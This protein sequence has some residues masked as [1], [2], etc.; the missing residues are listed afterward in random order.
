MADLSRHPDPA[1]RIGPLA[2][3]VRVAQE[4]L[5]A[6]T[7]AAEAARREQI[8]AINRLNEAQKAFDEAVAALRTSAPRDS[9]WHSERNVIGRATLA[10]SPEEPGDR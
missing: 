9:G 4:E 10:A 7:K 1:V 8:T 2:Q 6:R 3:A 5:C